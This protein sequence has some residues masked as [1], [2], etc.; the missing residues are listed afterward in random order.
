MNKKTAVF[1]IVSSIFFGALGGWVLMR[2]VLPSL[3]TSHLLMKYHL[4]VAGAPLVINTREEIRYSDG[5]DAVAGIQKADVSM[6]GI[7]SGTSLSNAQLQGS[8]LVLTS[9]G[10]LATVKSAITN[11]A[12]INVS[13]YDGTVLPATEVASDPASDLVFLK[14]SASRLTSASFGIPS[15]LQLGQKMVVLEPSLDE[16]EAFSRA[17]VISSAQGNVSYVSTFS[18]EQLITTFDLDNVANTQEGSIVISADG[19]VQGIMSHDSVISAD[20]IKSAMNSYFSSNKIVRN[21]IGLYY[22][23]IPM[24]LASAFNGT[25]GVLIK[26]PDPKTPAVVAGSPAQTAGILPGDIIYEVNGTQISSANSFET[27]LQQIQPGQT[28]TLSVERG[29]TQKIISLVVGSTK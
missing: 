24:T 18:T 12:A 11:P 13:L 27:L 3:S 17:T 7:I 26:Q 20:A 10:L 21:V 16:N 9:D 22:Q 2:W 8:G 25:E 19:N 28:A 6:V 14:I 1:I 15:G 29:T 23:Y 5:S 4:N